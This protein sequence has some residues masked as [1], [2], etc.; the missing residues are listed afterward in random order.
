MELNRPTRS[1]PLKSEA[2]GTCL[3]V[4]DGSGRWWVRGRSATFLCQP[5][6]SVCNCGYGLQGEILTDCEHLR[7]LKERIERTGYDCP[8]CLGLGQRTLKRSELLA[9]MEKGL[10]G[11]Y[12]PEPCKWCKGSGRAKNRKEYDAKLDA[13]RKAR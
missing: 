6:E 8:F 2:A 4:Q 11:E 1:D 10:A 9:L 13:K 7:N 5:E 12:Q 3:Q